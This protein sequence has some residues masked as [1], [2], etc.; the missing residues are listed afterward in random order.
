M[1][2]RCKSSTSTGFHR[3][4]GR[5]IKVCK[6]WD[7]F[8]KFLLDMGP[9]PSPAHTIDRKNNDG[10][11]TPN[12]CAWATM[13]E[14]ARNRRGN[15]FV[16]FKGRRM[17]LAEAVSIAGMSH[18]AFLARVKLGW[19]ESDALSIPIRR[20]GLIFKRDV[21]AIKKDQRPLRQIADA[22]GIGLVTVWRIKRGDKPRI[23]EES[24]A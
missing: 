2:R 9:R 4:G 20:H 1:R 10:D 12:N 19:T 24:K 21:T 14:Q 13:T 15:R 5:G 8:A 17:T 3:Y 7:S 23:Q 11:Y 22:Y 6:R 18:C 16:L